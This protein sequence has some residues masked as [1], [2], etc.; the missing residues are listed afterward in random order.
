MIGML[1][2]SLI[3]RITA[4]PLLGGERHAQEPANHPLIID[5]QYPQALDAHRRRAFPPRDPF[6]RAGV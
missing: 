2:L 4:M 5:D 6:L 1:L 3:R